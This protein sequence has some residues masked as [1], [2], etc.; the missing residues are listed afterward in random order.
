[1]FIVALVIA[2]VITAIPLCIYG[3]LSQESLVALF[4]I[5]FSLAIV[6]YQLLQYRK[7]AIEREEKDFSKMLAGFMIETSNNLAVVRDKQAKLSEI[8]IVATFFSD[9]VIRNV[10]SHTL[11]YRYIGY[12]ILM[13]CYLYLG[14]MHVIRIKEKNAFKQMQQNNRIT[15]D[16][17]KDLKATYEQFHKW[18]KYLQIQLQQLINIFNTSVGPDLTDRPHFA[19]MKTLKE[20]SIPELDK[21]LKDVTDISEKDL[22]MMRESY[23]DA[24]EKND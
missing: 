9:V 20:K 18:V 11:A 19:N 16:I 22:K 10:L 6:Y 5:L 17:V 21:F 14:Q 8:T 23:I 12:D 4:G 13:N 7:D 3:F 24:L 1:M 15:E 2:V